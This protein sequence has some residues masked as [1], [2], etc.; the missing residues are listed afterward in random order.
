MRL[1]KKYRQLLAMSTYEQRL[2][3]HY[4][5]MDRLRKEMKEPE[6]KAL[7]AAG[8][9]A[10]AQAFKAEANQPSHEQRQEE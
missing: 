3:E 8:S 9:Q 7:P 5:R 4:G 1:A 6:A 10:Q 2:A